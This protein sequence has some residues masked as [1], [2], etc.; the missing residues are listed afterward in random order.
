M[1]DKNRNV[2]EE[3]QEE[4]VVGHVY[5]E[6]NGGQEVIPYHVDF[7][8]ARV[9]FAPVGRSSE[10]QMR[11]SDFLNRFSYVGEVSSM[12]EKQ[13]AKTTPAKAETVAAR[14]AS[15]EKTAS[16]REANDRNVR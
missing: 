11:T 3:G 1:A 6:D 2:K 13:V 8:S 12:A 10:D 14:K 15:T 9:N 5:K 7:S 16:S 4:I